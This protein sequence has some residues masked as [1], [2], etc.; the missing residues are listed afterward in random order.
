MGCACNLA[1]LTCDDFCDSSAGGAVTPHAWYPMAP[2]SSFTTF[3]YGA[4]TAASHANFSAYKKTPNM[5]LSYVYDWV[6]D[7]TMKSKCELGCA[8]RGLCSA[9]IPSASPS[10]SSTLA[11]SATAS[12]THAAS[13]SSSGT[14]VSQTASQTKSVSSSRTPSQGSSASSS[15]SGSFSVSS[16][17]SQSA[18]TSMSAAGTS[19]PSSTSSSTSSKI[20]APLCDLNQRYVNIST[21]ITG[22]ALNLL[23]SNN[24]E[25]A[26][27]GYLCVDK[28]D[29]GDSD[30]GIVWHIIVNNGTNITELGKKLDEETNGTAT[31]T[32]SFNQ[33][34][35]KREGA[36]S[37]L[38]GTVLPVVGGLV[39][40]GAFAAWK[41]WQRRK[42]ESAT[43]AAYDV[44]TKANPYG[45][46]DED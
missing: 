40:L 25:L 27:M 31:V 35:R 39:V 15:R 21:N 26:E 14:A 1:S 7:S 19:S 41:F 32:K 34:D 33:S 29:K 28:K 12:S 37:S 10:A 38:L 6:E 23:L 8:A 17:A 30:G 43:V 16:F 5:D 36:G 11:V 22:L 4:I 18:S 13:A 45:D 44:S 46:E 20:V 24:V 3:A 9:P 2:S 42:K